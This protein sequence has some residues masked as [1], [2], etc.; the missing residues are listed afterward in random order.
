MKTKLLLLVAFFSFSLNSFAQNPT[1]YISGSNNYSVIEGST[2]NFTANLYSASTLPTVINIVT[3]TETAGGTDFTG[4]STTVTIPAGQ[5]SSTSL[6]INTTNDSTIEPNETFTLAGTVTSGNT[7]NTTASNTIT[8]IDN[9]KPPTITLYNSSFLEGQATT[10]SVNLS[11]PYSSAVVLNFVTTT[12]SAGATDYTSVTTTKT[13]AAGVTSISFSINT[14][15]DSL[16]ESD[17][18]FTLTGTVTSGNTANTVISRVITIIDNDTLPTID[19]PTAVNVAEG[20]SVNYYI[21]LNRAYNSNIIITFAA[22]SGT[23]GTSDYSFTTIT[24]TILAGSTYTTVL[25][26]PTNDTI[27]EPEENFTIIGTVASGNTT[28][29]TV[30]STINILDNDGLPDLSIYDSDGLTYE[31][32]DQIFYLSITTP[33]TTPTIVQVTTVNGTAGALDY[34]PVSTTV[35]IPANQYS[36]SFSTPTILDTLQETNE[37]YTVNAVVTS[38]NTFNTSASITATIFDNYNVNAH[39]ETVISI[40][41][42]G[43][44]FQ[45]LTNDTLHGLP[46]NAS[47]IT[48]TQPPNSNGITISPQGLLT[49]PSNLAMGYYQLSYKICEIANPN[50]CDTAS[51]IVQ[52]TSPLSA[53]YNLSYSDYNADGYVSAGDL[54]NYQFTIG[55]LGNAPISNINVN[56]SFGNL[57]ILGGPITSLPAGQS[58]TT[59]FSAIHILTQDDINYGYYSGNNQELFFAGT[60]YGYNV[61]SWAQSLN[62]FTLNFSDG[63]KVKAFVDANANGTQETSELNFPLGNFNYEINNNGILHNLYASPHYLYESNPTTN[64]KLTYTVDS[65]YAAYNTCTANYPNVTVPNG[66]GITTYNFPI[67]VTPYQ[68]L[69]VNIHSYNPPPRP[70]FYYY[71]YVVFKNNSYQTVP[72]GTVTFTKDGALSISNTSVSITLTT[73]G[74][75]HNFVNLLPYETRYI[76]VQMQVPTIPTVLLGQLVTNSVSITMLSGDILLL[77]NTSS[78]TQTIVGSYDPND[79][80]ESHGGKILHTSFTANDYLTYTI[81]FENTGTANAIN[82][83]VKDVLDVKLEPSSIRMIDASAPYSLER[84][85]TNLEWKFNGINL[86]PSVANTTTGKG[87]ITFQ[88]KPKVGYAVGD[89]IPNIANIFFDFNPAIVTAPC[90]T[91]FVSTLAINDFDA[92]ELSVY[93]NPVQNNLTITNTRTIDSVTVF[94]VLGQEVIYQKVN[95][96][97]AEINTSSLTNGVYFVKVTSEGKEKT[98]KIVKE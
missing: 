22:T 20:Q 25:V 6:S 61:S 59:T 43:T 41:E 49:V 84:I 8:I 58:D 64:Y 85:G 3:T 63:L 71:A 46:V 23:A 75:T 15:N 38:G 80:T 2:Y 36:V 31:G 69:S 76:W 52:V 72:S 88:V 34:N 40:A 95:A 90:T 62:N 93:P 10:V 35:T 70:G 37:T 60:Y 33:N 87:Y 47:D 91:Q 57:S 42:V 48:L 56:N 4:L 78:L 66:S 98:V 12:G 18:S 39:E 50:V 5:I 7:N 9:D 82:I 21:N 26:Q 83:K 68:D 45:V 30:T 97:Q 92:N 29:T 73:T 81:Q 13:I 77:N 79:K 19:V 65:Q 24:K 67:T 28:N 55:N 44:T 32:E 17:E 51:I 96:L 1:F 54:I 53:G 86:P 16:V 11:N 74:F 14:T 94:S 27:D 89:I